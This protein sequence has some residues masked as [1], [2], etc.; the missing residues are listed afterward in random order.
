MS[1]A[2]ALPIIYQKTDTH[3]PAPAVTAQQLHVCILDPMHLFGASP[4]GAM[5]WQPIRFHL[6]PPKQMN[7]AISRSAELEEPPMWSHFSPHA[8]V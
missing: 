1:Y 4:C 6:Y 3:S 5:T 8:H 2:Q 7:E